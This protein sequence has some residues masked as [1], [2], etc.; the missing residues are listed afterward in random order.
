MESFWLDM[1]IRPSLGVVK[2]QWDLSQNVYSKFLGEYEFLK[3][4]FYVTK[5]MCIWRKHEV[6]ERVQSLLY[7]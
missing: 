7:V 3:K 2:G 6:T 5:K 4:T 1:Q